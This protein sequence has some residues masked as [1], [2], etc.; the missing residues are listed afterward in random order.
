MKDGIRYKKIEILL[1]TGKDSI[2]STKIE[3]EKSWY[4]IESPYFIVSSHDDALTENVFTYRIFHMG[5]IHAF[6]TEQ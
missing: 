4:E 5:E 6:K 3:F 2:G 1:K